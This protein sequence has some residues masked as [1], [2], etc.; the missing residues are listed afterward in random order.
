MRRRQN[1]AIQ[2]KTMRTYMASAHQDV[3]TSGAYSKIKP[4]A[5]S[6][7]TLYA[8][9]A[10]QSYS[11]QNNANIYGF[12]SSR[13]RDK[14]NGESLC[15]RRR[16]NKAI[17]SETMRIY[18]ASAHQDVATRRTERVFVCDVGSIKLNNEKQS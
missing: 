3:A 2:S 14:T 17:Q 4:K 7:D 13:R 11:K 1:K 15:M 16:Q 10:K 6:S 8:T 18:M 5:E 12:C 9:S